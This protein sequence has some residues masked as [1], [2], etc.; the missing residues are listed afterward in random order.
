MLALGLWPAPA[1]AESSP[2]AS[3][4]QPAKIKKPTIR[5]F[6]DYELVGEIARGGMGVVYRARQVSLSRFVALKMIAA[7]QLATPAAMQRFHTE[8]EAA[9]RLDHPH[10]VPIYEIGQ[11]EG[12]HYYSMKLLEGGTLAGLNSDCSARDAEWQERKAVLLGTVARAVHYAHQRGILH[13]DLKPTNIL[14]DEQGEPHITDFGL[15]KLLEV[16][17]SITHSLAV[18]GTPA[19]MAPEQAAGGAKQLTTAADTYG[20]GAILY[21]LLTGQPPFHGETSVEVLRHVCERAPVPPRTL[22]PQV[23]RD[24][25]TICLKCLNKDPQKRYAS[26]ELLAQDLDYWRNGEPILARPPGALEKAWRWSR[27]HPVSAG[28]LLVLLLGITSGPAFVAWQRHRRIESYIAQSHTLRTIDTDRLGR[29]FESLAAITN[30]LRLNPTAAQRETLRNEAIACFAITDFRLVKQWSRQYLEGGSEKSAIWGFDL[31][32]RLLYAR[33]AERGEISVC[34]VADDREIARF[35]GVGSEPQVV[36]DFRGRFVTVQYWDGINRVW[37]IIGKKALPIPR[38][39]WFALSPDA[40]SVAVANTNGWLTFHDV[41]T[42]Q[43]TRQVPMRDFM[44]FRLLPNGTQYVRVPRQLDR[45]EIADLAT[46]KTVQTLLAPNELRAMNHS[47]DG[48]FI[49]GGNR[50][51]RVYLWDTETGERTDLVG[52]EEAAV[53]TVGFNHADTM[54]ESMAVNG[55][56]RLWDVSTGRLLFTG[57]SQG[58]QF[59]GDD[60][61]F[62]Y[63]DARHVFLL[64]PTPHPGLRLLGR[65]RRE[66]TRLPPP[67]FSPDDRLLA[68]MDTNSIH[69]WDA[70]VGKELA[71]VPEHGVPLFLPDGNNLLVSSVV[72][73]LYRLP[74]ERVE[75]TTNS[76]RFGP[77]SLLLAESKPGASF[78]LSRDGRSV[79][80]LHSNGTAAL[81]FDLSDPSKHVTLDTGSNIVDSAAISPDGRMVAIAAAQGPQVQVWDVASRRVVKEL[82]M[83]ASMVVKVCFSADGRW[84]AVSGGRENEPVYRLYRTGSWELRLQLTSSQD[85]LAEPGLCAFS[86]DGEIWAIGNPPNHTRLYSTATGRRLAVLEPPH[87]APVASLAF[88]PDG[89]TL[90]VMQRDSVVQVWDLRELRQ[91]LAALNLDWDLP[92][93]PPATH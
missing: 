71:A 87:Q 44:P 17:G 48:R 73:G 79:V 10:I 18:L 64:E 57:I 35:P 54:L 90:A 77:R 70:V 81:V 6:G 85:Q 29:R 3:E 46:G 40:R 82:P 55:D 31:P 43:Q 41:D 12:Q 45:V 32:T 80:A 42:L 1:A 36:N 67:A 15:A 61:Y 4:N 24:L 52:D 21:E 38:C 66:T 49:A 27:R 47:T 78:D 26:A 9:A 19:Y 72:G 53:G 89:N 63:T 37:D 11:Y 74:I 60:G 16:D 58:C 76:M 62:S 51:G 83:P 28:L 84:L 91:E 22:N 59:A 13:R 7:G 68:T 86:P 2:S 65:A 93:Y 39:P 50:S 30:A 25:E 33:S 8:A 56:F 75:G 69:L 34:Q 88:S 5:Y 14:L 20:L 92:P 23:D